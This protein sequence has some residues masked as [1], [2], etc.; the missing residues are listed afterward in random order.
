MMYLENA[1]E[2]RQKA[3]GKERMQNE[4]ERSKKVRK[5][6]KS[7]KISSCRVQVGLV[8]KL[9]LV[10]AKPFHAGFEP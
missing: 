9:R 1:R 2:G 7:N 3:R 5:K 8:G 6:K 4:T 10:T